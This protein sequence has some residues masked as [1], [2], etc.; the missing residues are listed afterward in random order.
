[1]STF[2]S[3]LLVTKQALL[4][5][6]RY[7]PTSTSYMQE[8]NTIWVKSCLCSTVRSKIAHQCKLPF[9]CLLLKTLRWVEYLT[10]CSTGLS[11]TTCSFPHGSG[12]YETIM[13]VPP[14]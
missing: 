10:N 3:Y 11:S 13:V 2:A 5:K 1:M 14:I 9:Y 4:A 12:D 7:K 6:G 8:C